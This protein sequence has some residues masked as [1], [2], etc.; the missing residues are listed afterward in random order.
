MSQSET[1]V[2]TLVNQVEA[3]HL[4]ASLFPSLSPKKPQITKENE[5]KDETKDTSICEQTMSP[6]ALPPTI[7][8]KFNYNQTPVCRVEISR[9]WPEGFQKGNLTNG[10][11]LDANM[12]MCMTSAAYNPATANEYGQDKDMVDYLKWR[13]TILQKLITKVRHNK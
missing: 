5:I 7:S 3:L 9:M 12:T 11:I 10:N 13:E 1:T 6:T 2:N 8:P 4:D